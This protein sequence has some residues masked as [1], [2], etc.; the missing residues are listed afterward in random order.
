MLLD[1]YVVQFLLF[2]LPVHCISGIYDVEEVRQV[3]VYLKSIYLFYKY[4]PYLYFRSRLYEPDISNILSGIDP[5]FNLSTISSRNNK[6]GQ[7]FACKLPVAEITEKSQPTSYNPK[8]LAELVTASFYIKNC[9]S[10]DNGWWK[11]KLCRG[12]DVK[13][14]H[15]ASMFISGK[16]K[17]N[18]LVILLESFLGT[19]YAEAFI[20]F[21]FQYECDPQLSTSE[22]YI[23]HVEEVVSCEYVITVKVGSL[24][25]LTAFMPPNLIAFRCYLENLTISIECSVSST[26]IFHILTVI[27]SVMKREAIVTLLIV[28]ITDS[29]DYESERDQDT[30]NLWY[31]FHDNLWN[32]THFPKS[33]N[34]VDVIAI[35]FCPLLYANSFYFLP[36]CFVT[37]IF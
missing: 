25:S 8:Y 27:V 37:L 19:E 6:T 33:L 13:Q 9:I 29:F 24:C 31:Y 17:H 22:A 14:W 16:T 3:D 23:D 30:G 12:V 28:L 21:S 5:S 2:L 26:S 7:S 20:T 1:L 36:Y 34:Y 15:G 35:L 11:Y 4:L 18:K 32:K 10:K